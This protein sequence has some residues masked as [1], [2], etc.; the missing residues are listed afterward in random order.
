[1]FRIAG[2]SYIHLPALNARESAEFYR[3]VFGWELRGDPENPSFSDG[4]GHVT[5][6]WVTHRGASAD[7]GVIPY[8]YVNDVQQTLDRIIDHGGTIKMQPFPE[9]DLTVALFQDPGGNAI[10]VWQRATG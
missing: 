2:I 1:M 9:G 7:S 8:I 10:G 4:T 3:D 5:G 6:G